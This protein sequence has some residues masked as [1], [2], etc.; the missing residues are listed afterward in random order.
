MQQ[1]LIE[2]NLAELSAQAWRLIDAADVVVVDLDGCLAADN[3]PLP[4]AS[5]F[6]RRVGGKLVVASNNSTHCADQLSDI[7]RRNG[8]PVLAERFV[9]AGELAVRIVAQQRPGARV[10]LL[11]TKAIREAALGAGLR[12]V[13]D[14]PDVVL[15]TRAVTSGFPQFEAAVAALHRGAVLVVTNP[16]LSHCGVGGEPR[17]ETG[18]LLALFRSVLPGLECLVIGKPELPLLQAAL[19]LHDAQ[20]ERAVMIGDNAATDIEGA[21]RIGMHAIHLTAP[22]QRISHP[23][24]QAVK[25]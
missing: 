9:L 8:L 15:L 7:L 12:I 21:R 14:A 20:P 5:D 10:M 17:I 2:A 1:T 13:V 6:A 4:G 3:V 23:L 16:D 22:L 18:A 11:G 19:A 24:S 25:G